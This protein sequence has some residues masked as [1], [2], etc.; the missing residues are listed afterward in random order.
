MKYRKIIFAL[1]L[2]LILLFTACKEKE[3]DRADFGNEYTFVCEVTSS[4]ATFNIKAEKKSDCWEF[5]YQS[6]A[7]LEGLTVGFEGEKAKTS[8]KGV[9]EEVLRE[10]LPKT[11]IANIVAS[12]FDYLQSGKG[13][14][15]KEVGDGK[16]GKGV[17]HGVKLEAKFDKS[18]N[19]R[20]I[21]ISDE[22]EIVITDFKRT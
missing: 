11:N 9:D 14:T 7:E 17:L 18:D 6:P 4:D 2:T 12:S 21:V 15:F 5:V 8:F 3:T 19:P 22:Y 1:A 16:S 13:L 10:K 20:N